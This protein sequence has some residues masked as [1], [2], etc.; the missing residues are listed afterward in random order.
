MKDVDGPPETA[1][2]TRPHVENKAK[3]GYIAPCSGVERHIG[4]IEKT[5]IPGRVRATYKNYSSPPDASRILF[6]VAY[7]C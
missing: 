4:V 2:Q 3:N 1:R 6:S 5:E 7:C